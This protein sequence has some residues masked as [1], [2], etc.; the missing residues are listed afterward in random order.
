LGVNLNTRAGVGGSGVPSGAIGCCH[1]TI[2]ASSTAL[3][4]IAILTPDV[5]YTA[6][7]GT[8]YLSALPPVSSVPEPGTLALIAVAVAGLGFSRRRK[9]H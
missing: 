6:A 5:Y 8:Q 1:Q 2:D 3:P 9:L 7:S 4:A